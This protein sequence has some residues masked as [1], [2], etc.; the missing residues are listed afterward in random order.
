MASTLNS[1]YTPTQQLWR[2]AVAIVTLRAKDTMGEAYHSR[3]DKAQWLVLAGHVNPADDGHSA[4][5]QSETKAEETYQVNGACECPDARS[6]A[7]AGFCKHRLAWAIYRRA[8]EHGQVLLEMR[9]SA[10]PNQPCAAPPQPVTLPEAPVSVTLKG[11][12]R[13]C[14]GTLV[15]VRGATLAEVQAQLEAAARLFDATPAAKTE[16]P[17]PVE[18]RTGY[19]LDEEQMPYCPEHGVHYRK[20]T[21]NGQSWYSHRTESG[22]CR[23][24]G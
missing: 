8:V 9:V 22:W 19:G 13:G 7:P 6:K 21:K 4:T 5:V 2:D 23:Y 12:V 1:Q 16:A 17:H 14:A 20:Q 15:T 3:L 11:T 24:K 18:C 10:N